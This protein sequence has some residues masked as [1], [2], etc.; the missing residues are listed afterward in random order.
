M[1]HWTKNDAE[2]HKWREG[3][4]LE[5]TSLEPV[6]EPLKTLGKPLTPVLKRDALNLKP[7]TA[8]EG[9]FMTMTY[10]THPTTQTSYTHTHTG[11]TYSTSC[12]G[13]LSYTDLY[14]S[15]VL[16]KV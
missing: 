14:I 6:L 5:G 7:D 4:S 1:V 13:A 10:L 8:M 12:L 15:K 11:H 16:S 3:T 2:G 9:L